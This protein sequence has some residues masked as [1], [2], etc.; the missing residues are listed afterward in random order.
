MDF[1]FKC[2][3][4]L[5][6]VEVEALPERITTKILTKDKLKGVFFNTVFGADPNIENTPDNND[7]GSAIDALEIDCVGYSLCDGIFI[8]F[9][10]DQQI[11]DSYEREHQLNESLESIPYLRLENITPNQLKQINQ[12]LQR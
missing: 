8:K 5:R 4:Q 11:P 10:S 7:I 3:K 6:D 12:L 2:F 9:E 1:F